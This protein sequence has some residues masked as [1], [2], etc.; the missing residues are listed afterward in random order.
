MKENQIGALWNSRT[1]NPKAPFAKGRVAVREVT[2][3]ML[4][5]SMTLSERVAELE[6]W[7]I[8]TD[9]RVAALEA[10]P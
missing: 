2:R 7:R 10:K 4:S 5:S 1:E 3:A 9:K 6:R 8:D